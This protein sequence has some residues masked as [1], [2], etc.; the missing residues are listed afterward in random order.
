MVKI[1]WIDYS[2]YRREHY[3]EYMAMG[4]VVVIFGSIFLAWA[5]SAYAKGDEAQSWPKVP[6]KVVQSGVVTS[7][8]DEHAMLYSA[9]VKY[10]YTVNGVP[11]SST[12]I[13]PMDTGSTDPRPAISTITKYQVGQGVVV[14]YDPSHPGYSLLETDPGNSSI[15]FM[16]AGLLII[17]FGVLII[18]LT[19]R[20]KPRHRRKLY[21]KL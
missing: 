5:L 4:V 14:M 18:I 9:Y 7:T 12:R 6:G 15:V 21:K 2:E 1:K 13:T 11:Y 8:D 16:V 20:S 19:M 3:R 17:A 10:N